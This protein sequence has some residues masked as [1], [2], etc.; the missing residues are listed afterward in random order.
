[1][2]N[3]DFFSLFFFHKSVI[4]RAVKMGWNSRVNPAHHVFGLDWIENFSLISI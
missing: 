2:N 1:M 3:R 4:I